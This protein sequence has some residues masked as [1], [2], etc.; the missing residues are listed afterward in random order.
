MSRLTSLGL[1]MYAQAVQGVRPV[2][3][4]EHETRVLSRF[5]VQDGQ[6]VVED[7]IVCSSRRFRSIDDG[8]IALS[9]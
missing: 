2:E 9:L 5:K 6:R 1:V 3:S 7:L 4:T 8:R